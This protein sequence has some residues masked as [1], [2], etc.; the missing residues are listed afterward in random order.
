MSVSLD[1]TPQSISYGRMHAAI[2]RGLRKNNLLALSVEFGE[3]IYRAD[4]KRF[5]ERKSTTL[6]G[7]HGS[8]VE[9]A[10]ECDAVG[11]WAPVRSYE[12][13]CGDACWDAWH[14]DFDRESYDRRHYGV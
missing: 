3:R 13:F 10:K 12:D 5:E 7:V 4:V 6:V 9:D 14:F 8:I 1:K 11:C 2:G